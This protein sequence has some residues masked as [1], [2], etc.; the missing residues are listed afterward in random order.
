MPH[1]VWILNRSRAD[2]PPICARA[3]DTF[4]CKLRG[5]TFR[6]KLPP[7]E[8]LLLI[9]EKDSRINASI[10]MLFM[11]MD[12]AVVWIDS[13]NH[14][15]DVRFARRWRPAYFP[16]KPARYILEMPAEHLNDFSTGD[17]VAIERKNGA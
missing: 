4:F 3:C 17:L 7:G 15:V 16:A 13:S 11:W 2:H 5:L 12:L 10:H 6:K 1:E 14:V 9:E 8:G